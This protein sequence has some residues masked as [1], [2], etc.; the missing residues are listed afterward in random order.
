LRRRANCGDDRE[1]DRKPD[2]ASP[3]LEPF[4]YLIGQK[5]PRPRPIR[6]RANLV[7]AGHGLEHFRVRGILDELVGTDAVQSSSRRTVASCRCR[8]FRMVAASPLR[9]AGRRLGR[10]AGLWPDI[11]K[12]IH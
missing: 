1:P 7:H 10:V 6:R 12:S 3:R 9:R 5:L 4:L 8:H 2:E 11:P